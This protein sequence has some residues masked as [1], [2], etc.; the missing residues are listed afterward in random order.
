MEDEDEHALQSVEDGEEV[1][2]HNGRVVEEKQ[3]KRPREPQET[4]KGKR[5]QHP[6]PAQEKR[7]W[8]PEITVTILNQQAAMEKSCSE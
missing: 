5:S 3:A 6:W 8:K 2:H 4:E 1:R 7:E